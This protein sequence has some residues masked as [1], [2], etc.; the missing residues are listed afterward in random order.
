MINKLYALLLTRELNDDIIK[1]I[2]DKNYCD[3]LL[4]KYSVALV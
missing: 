3:Y 1:A 2:R 4:K